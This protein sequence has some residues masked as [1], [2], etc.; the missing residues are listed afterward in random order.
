MD[1]RRA[2]AELIDEGITRIRIVGDHLGPPNGHESEGWVIDSK[3]EIAFII[4]AFLTSSRDFEAEIHSAPECSETFMITTKRHPEPGGERTFHVG[5]DD[6]DAYWGSDM[7][8]V[9]TRYAKAA[10]RRWFS[11]RKGRISNVLVRRSAAELIAEGIKRIELYGSCLSPD[12]P[13]RSLQVLK[14]ENDIAFIMRAFLNSSRKEGA[15]RGGGLGDSSDTFRIVT[16]S[17]EKP[18]YRVDSGDVHDYWGPDMVRV[19]AKYAN[20]ESR[21]WFTEKAK[22]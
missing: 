20:A 9:F 1:V 15:L 5:I 18:E 11:S 12:D 22:P 13:D 21:H 2:A 16:K 7:V 4:K 3:D 17:I 10:S 14:S 6:L 8:R 19:Y